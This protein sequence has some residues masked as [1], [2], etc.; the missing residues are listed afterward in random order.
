MTEPNTALQPPTLR[1]NAFEQYEEFFE[2]ILEQSQLTPE[3]QTSLGE[4]LRASVQKRDKL[5]NCL[6][7]L[8][9]QAD[10]LR[11]KEK[12]LAERRGHFEK[13]LHTLTSSLH[14]QMLDI[15]VRKVEG[16]EFS[17]TIKKNPPR[18]E[19]L[20]EAEIPPE[21]ISYSPVVDRAAIKNALEEGK[22]VLGVK[23][24]QSTRLD[25]R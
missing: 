9:S 12:R 19:I 11:A 8:K 21:F 22:A 18:V 7:W 17:F 15:G 10:L 6:E 5:G 20:N 23:L 13:L 25:V 4:Q 16:L 24:V 2:T 3:Q 1:E 14:Q